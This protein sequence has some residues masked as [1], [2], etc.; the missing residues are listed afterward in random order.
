M[1][2]KKITSIIIILLVII[3]GG[4]YLLFFSNF[5]EYKRLE[6]QY[7]GLTDYINEIKKTDLMIKE[8]R[9]KSENYLHS[10]LAWKSL[11]DR[12]AKKTYYAQA[13]KVYEKGIELTGRRNT[14]FLVNAGN[15]AKFMNDFVLAEEYYREAISVTPG[16]FEIYLRLI[17]LYEYT[18]KKSD[19]EILAIYDAAAKRVVTTGEVENSRKNFKERRNIIQ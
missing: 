4:V 11:A 15:M 6:V 14:I 8:D 3:A 9:G 18:L 5:L 10:G 1:K 13:L 12:T 7:P 2:S 19:E 17:E 16:D